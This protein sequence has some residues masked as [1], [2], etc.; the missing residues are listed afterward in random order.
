MST[1]SRALPTKPRLTGLRAEIP[2]AARLLIL[3]SMPGALSLA[4]GE[5]YAHPRNQ[6]WAIMQALLGIDRDTPYRQRVDALKARSIG[7]WDVLQSCERS[8]SLDTAIDLGSVAVND[9]TAVLG[10]GRS[11]RRVLCNGALA[12]KLFR[13]RVGPG[14]D[15]PPE[16]HCLPSTSPAHAAVSLDHKIAQWR[17]AFGNFFAAP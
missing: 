5:Y 15:D 10:R 11:V 9:F 2:P 12:A 16:V 3:G 13:Q 4:A 1:P 6:F 14:L 8:G 7:L 17:E